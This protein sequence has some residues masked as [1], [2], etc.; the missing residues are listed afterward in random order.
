MT[1]PEKRSPF[2]VPYTSAPVVPE[3][4]ENFSRFDVIFD[5]FQPPAAQDTLE[6]VEHRYEWDEYRRLVPRRAGNTP[7]DS[8]VAAEIKALLPGVT[9]GLNEEGR[10]Y[11]QRSW[12]LHYYHN[13]FRLDCQGL[14]W[15]NRRMGKRGGA[16]A[17]AGRPK[18]ELAK[19]VEEANELLTELHGLVRDGFRL[20]ADNLPALIKKELDLAMWNQGDTPTVDMMRL[21]MQSRHFLIDMLVKGVRVSEHDGGRLQEMFAMW[22]TRTTEEIIVVK[23]PV[24]ASGEGHIIDAEGRTIS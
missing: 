12:S 13:T 22:R 19:N 8:D 18:K 17:G 24:D 2:G 16:R 21:S 5:F 1:T 10:V 4:F 6:P 14:V 11:A 9:T 20:A 15:Y 3:E 23:Q 7:R